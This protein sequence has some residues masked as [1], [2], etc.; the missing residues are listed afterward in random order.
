MF[1][2]PHSTPGSNSNIS[3]TLAYL[4]SAPASEKTPVLSCQIF[5][6]QSKYFYLFFHSYLPPPHLPP[7]YYPQ[8]H[9]PCPPCMELRVTSL[10]GQNRLNKKKTVLYPAAHVICSRMNPYIP[11]L[12]KA[13]LSLTPPWGLSF[14]LFFLTVGLSRALSM[15]RAGELCVTSGRRPLTIHNVPQRHTGLPP[16]VY[17]FKFTPSG[18]RIAELPPIRLVNTRVGVL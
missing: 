17:D 7:F 2:R 12:S 4:Q 10:L 15:L 9:D 14:S 6:P 13:I 5:P 1:T 3:V 8:L 18:R 16:N 11:P